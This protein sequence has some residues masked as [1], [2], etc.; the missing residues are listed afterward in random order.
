MPRSR[1]P[2]EAGTVGASG[3]GRPRSPAVWTLP[4]PAAG[5]HL[6]G[7]VRG[8]GG[9]HSGVSGLIA[10]SSPPGPALRATPSYLTP[11]LFLCRP[12]GSP[13]HFPV[14]SW[15]NG[16]SL[17]FSNPP[18]G[19]WVSSN[20]QSLRLGA[21]CSNRLR[22]GSSSADSESLELTLLRIRPL[23]PGNG[24]ISVPSANIRCQSP[25]RYEEPGLQSCGPERK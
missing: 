15:Q 16:V 23:P 19:L 10:A 21:E 17:M 9:Q 8:A 5:P 2:Q 7:P 3:A 18:H 25:Q 12:R 20:H 4:L 24:A 1:K 22:Y 13:L 11:G 6:G 14:F